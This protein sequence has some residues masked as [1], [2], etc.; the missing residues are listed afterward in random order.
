MKSKQ[1]CLV[2]LELQIA[3]S[4]TDIPTEEFFKACVEHALSAYRN[5]AELTIRLV[6]REEACALNRRWGGHDVATNVLSFPV[7]DIDHAAPDLLGDVVLCA[8]LVQAE[9]QAQGKSP[10]AHWAHLV[11]HGV[12]H[13]LGFGHEQASQ[14]QEMEDV[15]RAVLA[16]MGYPDPYVA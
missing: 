9:A 2:F 14:A 8:P 15:E 13:L 10:E 5:E 7:E 6:D 1:P 16:E 12:L 11:V 4:S 3:S